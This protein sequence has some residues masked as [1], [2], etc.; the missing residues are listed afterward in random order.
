MLILAAWAL[1]VVADQPVVVPQPKASQDSQRPPSNPQP[2]PTDVDGV[3]VTAPK[4]FREPAWAKEFN[5]DIRGIYRPS[6]T[7]Y[8]QQRPVDDCKLMAGGATSAIGR[9]GAAGGLVCVKR[10]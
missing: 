10:F 4:L 5:F 3:V 1:A 7:P 8:L 2:P 6:D 9:S